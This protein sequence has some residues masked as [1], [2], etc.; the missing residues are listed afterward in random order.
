M[1]TS[2]NVHCLPSS[3]QRKIVDTY[4]AVWSKS[5]NEPGRH[6]PNTVSSERTVNQT[7]F[8]APFACVGSMISPQLRKKQRNGIPIVFSRENML[9]RCPRNSRDSSNIALSIRPLTSI[10][11]APAWNTSENKPKQRPRQIGPTYHC[12]SS[13]GRMSLRVPSKF[14]SH[15]TRC[16]LSHQR[17]RMGRTGASL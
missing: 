10:T 4:V 3:F 1:P 16:S 9:I 5:R 6:T 17:R 14:S 7:P 11:P 13:Q 2:V 8:S 12:E 15:Y